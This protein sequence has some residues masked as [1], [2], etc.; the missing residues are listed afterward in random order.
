MRFAQ[1]DSRRAFLRT[2]VGY[3]LAASANTAS[4][5]GERWPFERVSGQFHWHADFGFTE[6]QR[7]LDEMNQLR[8][9]LFRELEL[10][11][12]DE[13]IHIFIFQHH[14][15]YQNYLRY[16][17]PKAPG[18]RAMYIKERGQGMLFTYKSDELAVDIRHEGTHALLHSVLPMVPLWLDEGLAEYFEVPRDDRAYGNE[19]L[20]TTKWQARFGQTPKLEKLE[21]LDDLAS[22]GKTEYRQ[23]WAWVHFLLHG[24]A[25]GRAELIRFLAD[26]HAHTPPGKLSDRLR[27]SVPQLDKRLAEHFKTW[28]R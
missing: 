28:Q 22:M 16:Y 23:S 20:S 25:E 10:A 26:V 17:F 4:P 9:D 1:R 27:R 21:T 24:S 11:A 2:L 6:Q 5:A 15:T 18:R 8:G 14:S 13:P 3:A 19:Y 7:L 12:S